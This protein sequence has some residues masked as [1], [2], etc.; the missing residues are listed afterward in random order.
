M[1]FLALARQKQS[2][3][4]QA[5]SDR[6]LSSKVTCSGCERVINSCMHRNEM[7][8]HAGVLMRAGVNENIYSDGAA[9]E[10]LMRRGVGGPWVLIYEARCESAEMPAA[11]GGAPLP[12]WITIMAISQWFTIK[13]SQARTYNL[14]T[15]VSWRKRLWTRRHHPGGSAWV[16]RSLWIRVAVGVSVLLEWKWHLRRACGDASRWSH[17]D[18]NGWAAG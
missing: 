5:S 8:W 6:W 2:G 13:L 11:R 17:A 14:D 16:C 12:S 1:C 10:L 9:E 18:S 3:R 7:F 4:M 15:A